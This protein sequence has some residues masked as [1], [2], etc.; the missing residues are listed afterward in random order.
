[1]MSDNKVPSSSSSSSS[2][3][4]GTASTVKGGTVVP[5]DSESGLG[6]ILT[7][8]RKRTAWCE[9]ILEDQSIKER[10][11]DGSYIICGV[12][13][14]GVGGNGATLKK[15]CSRRPY[16]TERWNEHIQ[17]VCHKLALTQNNTRVTDFFKPSVT[18]HQAALSGEK[19]PS[20]LTPS[21]SAVNLNFGGHRSSNVQAVRLK[22]CP[23]MFA[24]LFKHESSK[25]FKLFEEFGEP[26]VSV[27]FLSICDSKAWSIHSTDCDKVY[28]L[29]PGKAKSGPCDNCLAIETRA[30]RKRLLRMIDVAGVLKILDAPAVGESAVLDEEE[31]RRLKNFSHGNHHTNEAKKA[32]FKRVRDFLSYHDWFVNNQGALRAIGVPLPIGCTDKKGI[33]KPDEFITQF[34][35]LYHSQPEFRDPL[36]VGL[37]KAYVDKMSGLM[38]PQYAAKVIDFCQVMRLRSKAA[39]EIL[40]ANLLTVSVRQLQRIGSADRRTRTTAIDVDRESIIQSCK[41][42]VS[43]VKG[44]SETLVVSLEI[45]ATKVPKRLEVNATYQIRVGKIAPY[46]AEKLSEGM[47]VENVDVKELASAVKC[48]VLSAQNGRSG[49]FPMTLL[50]ALPQSTSELSDFNEYIVD[51]VTSL[52]DVRLVSVSCD[53]LASESDFI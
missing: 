16:S 10:A 21:S 25:Y 19:E 15:I 27:H 8:K 17:T 23:G 12:C 50:A 53:G 28:R 52:D 4:M 13:K 7:G 41:E 47:S 18:S 20:S 38:N 26:P 22:L 35:F 2:N 43:S 49:A 24:N 6:L 36:L 31:Y 33:L 45:D 11:K 51:I 9:A 40:Q 46:H 1:M 34:H 3:V 5:S 29:R 39:Y 42:W 14:T 44:E 37:A 32:L 30:L 48:A